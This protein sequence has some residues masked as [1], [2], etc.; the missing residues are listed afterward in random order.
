MHR[1]PGIERVASGSS[2]TVEDAENPT[3]S[4]STIRPSDNLAPVPDVR[5]NR[6]NA[7]IKSFHRGTVVTGVN[8]RHFLRIEGL[9]ALGIALGTYFE[10][11]G[12]LWLLAVLALAP[13]VSML[14]YLAG[15]RIG[16]LSYNVFHTYTVPIV[17]GGVGFWADVP[18]AVLV[19]AVWVGHIGVD[20][21]VGFG[22]KYET[23]FEDTHLSKQPAPFDRFT[24]E[25]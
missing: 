16:A 23:G 1:D 19:A 13:D 20:R 4:G 2:L 21:V 22:L 24:E 6:I 11:G 17:L 3:P 10:L 25:R 5:N 14:G 15:P 7:P 9:A 8:P 12:P 18:L